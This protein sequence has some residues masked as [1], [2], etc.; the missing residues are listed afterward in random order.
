[1]TALQ[2]V[3]P[4]WLEEDQPQ[5]AGN[6]QIKNGTRILINTTKEEILSRTQ[7]VLTRD[8]IDIASPTYLF[9]LYDLSKSN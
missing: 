6:L 2:F 1:M 7:M 3:I 5:N 9:V 4:P 8:A